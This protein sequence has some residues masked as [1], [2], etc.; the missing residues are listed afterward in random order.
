M[1]T[2]FLK[3]ALRNLLKYKT[4]TAISIIGLAIGLAFFIYGLHWLHYETSYDSFYPEAERSYLVYTQTENNKGGHSPRILTQFIREYC[5]EAEVITRSYEGGM[6]NMDYMAGNERIKNPDFMQVDSAFLDIFPQIILHGRKLMNDNEIIVSES[7]AKTHYGSAEKALGNELQQTAPA[8]FY[9]ADA[10][11][12]QIVGIMENAPQNSTLTPSGYLQMSSS[13]SNNIYQP[14]EW[15]YDNGL[16]HVMLKKG[17]KRSDFEKHLNTSLA[18]L[19]FLKDKSFKVIPLS[20][21]HFE[22]ASE[23]SFS[24]SAISMFTI[25]TGLLL[26]CVLFNFMNL[27]LNRYYQ[28]VR[29]VKLRKAV[30]ASHFKLILQVMLEI[31]AYCLIGFK[32]RATLARLCALQ[33]P[34]V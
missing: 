28:R 8:G 2:H 15:K 20:Q 27:F 22:F 13:A 18:Q 19:D 21:K 3:I 7:F 29:E 16:T 30:G 14:E 17:Y 33:P 32:I 34:A 25:A 9:L 31:T 12:L 10:R 1:I 23:E 5:P 6:G 24:Y 4:Q 11:K 26:C